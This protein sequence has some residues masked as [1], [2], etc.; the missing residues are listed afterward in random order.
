[1]G[2]RGSKVSLSKRLRRKEL[3]KQ[4]IDHLVVVISQLIDRLAG[5]N[6][7]LVERMREIQVIKILRQYT[8]QL[9]P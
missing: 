8:L 2:V 5:V 6:S 4:S 9:L 3:N 1:M 7:R